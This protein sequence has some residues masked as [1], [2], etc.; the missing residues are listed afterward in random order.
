MCISSWVGFRR[1][2]VDADERGVRGAL[3][4]RGLDSC[5]EFWNGLKELDSCNEFWKGL[6]EARSN[7]ERVIVLFA[8][9]VLQ[10]EQRITPGRAEKG[11]VQS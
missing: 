3:R 1:A 10:G 5:K 6:K 7:E 11:L 9:R 2:K 8:L 4:F